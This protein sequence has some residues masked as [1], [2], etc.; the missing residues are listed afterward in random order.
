MV[1]TVKYTDK[2]IVTIR[3]LFSV[4]LKCQKKGKDSMNESISW[5]CLRECSGMN[6][7]EI[8]VTMRYENS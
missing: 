5:I 1:R 6:V 8:S 4:L 3:S 7:I 2:C